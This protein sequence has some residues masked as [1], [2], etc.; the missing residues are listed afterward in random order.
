MR[1]MRESGKC[2]ANGHCLLKC[3]MQ[4]LQLEDADDFKKNQKKF[5]LMSRQNFFLRVRAELKGD[6][7]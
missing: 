7:A 3:Q 6:S 5:Q 4:L 1:V 2:C